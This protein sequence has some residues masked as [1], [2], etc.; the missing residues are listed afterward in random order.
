MSNLL[1]VRGL[2]VELPTPAGWVRPV[3]AVSLR[4]DAGKPLGLVGESGSGKTMLALA[5]MGLL[6][7]WA[8]VKGEEWL[9]KEVD[10]AKE[11]KEKS[12]RGSG[13]GA[14]KNLVA[15]NEREWRDVR[16]GEI[17]MVFQEPMTS[18]NPVMRIVAS[19]SHPSNLVLTTAAH[20]G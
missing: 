19:E 17:A 5:L 11:A 14:G 13:I 4:I 9:E 7:A 2:T 3:S 1:D 16:G 12:A 6:P 10:E 18:L 20:L 15:L 8:R